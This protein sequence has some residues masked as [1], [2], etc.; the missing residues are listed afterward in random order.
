MSIRKKSITPLE[1]VAI[2]DFLRLDYKQFCKVCKC[3]QRSYYKYLAGV[4][5]PSRT[6]RDELRAMVA[7]VVQFVD[8]TRE[9]DNT[10]FVWLP[11]QQVF[12]VEYPDLN[13]FQYRAICMHLLGMGWKENE[14]K[15]MSFVFN[16]YS[17]VMS[18]EKL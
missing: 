3:S 6:R 15:Y 14:N 16:E 18:E 7:Y 10:K 5:E 17:E 12:E 1:I 2:R 11:D 8:F 4:Q 9:H 13:F